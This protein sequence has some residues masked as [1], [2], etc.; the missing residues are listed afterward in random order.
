MNWSIRNKLILIGLLSAIALTALQGISLYVNKEISSAVGVSDLTNKKLTLVEDMKRA[1]LELILAAMDS[2]IDKDEGQIQPERKTVI[3]ESLTALREKGKALLD[4]ET[5]APAKKALTDIITK[6]DPLAQGIQVDLSQLIE[7]KAPVSEFAKIDDVIDTYG[8]GMSEALAK[9][10]EHLKSEFA[11]SISDVHTALDTSFK[12]GLAAYAVAVA[13]LSL[14]LLVIGKGII[15]G[16]GTMARTMRELASGNETIEVPGVGRHDEIGEMAD[17][18]QV[19]KENAVEVRKLNEDRLAQ[20][21]RADEQRRATLNSLA[22]D[23]DSRVGGIVGHVA[24]AVG[25]LGRSSTTMSAAADQAGNQASTVAA[26]SEEAAANV[27]TVASAAEELSSSIQEI[28]RQVADST[29][30]SSEA[31]AEIEQ[32]TQMVQSL[33]EAAVRIGEVVNLITDIA[34]QTNLLALNATIEAARAGEAGKGFAVVAAEV[35]NLASQTARATDEISS[36]INGIQTATQSSADAISGI[37]AT[38]GRMNEITANVAAA[39]EEQGAATA[40]I[41]RNVE[42]ASAG[43]QEVSSNIQG[44]TAA[45]SE[46]ADVAREI[47]QAAADL[48]DQAQSLRQ[49]VTSFLEEIREN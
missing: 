24:Q 39:V 40:E 3:A 13:V 28:S 4:L 20:E 27:Q 38:I 45:V 35:K 46:T 41:A 18:V 11:R 25:G 7:S 10:S 8:E 22:D 21:E 14:I 32:T 15:G 48:N 6:I 29:R 16:I 19:F 31:V 44:V 37:S 2:I 30:I 12:G 36:Q 26:A 43:T 42:Q 33:T 49:S 17:A 5:D 9:F 23:F 34:E 1:N 47:Q